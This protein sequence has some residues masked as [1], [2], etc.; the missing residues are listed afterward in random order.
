MMHPANEWNIGA[1]STLDPLLVVEQLMLVVPPL[2]SNAFMFVERLF[3]RLKEL[4]VHLKPLLAQ[5]PEQ[6]RSYNMY[7]PG[8][9][10]WI[11]GVGGG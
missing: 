4:P 3:W 8:G 10:G 1:H 9:P 11:G 6:E 7:H 2:E 5:V